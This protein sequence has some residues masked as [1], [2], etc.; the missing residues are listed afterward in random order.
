MAATILATRQEHGNHA[1]T[2]SDK[3]GN[4]SQLPGND[5]SWFLKAVGVTTTPTALSDVEGDGE[6]TTELVS[7][8]WTRGERASD[9]FDGWVPDELSHAVDSERRFRWSII[10]GVALTLA[11]I[12]VA[13]VWL[14]GSSDGRAATRADEY[15]RVLTDLRTDLPDAQSVLAQITEPGADA[16][17]FADL[18]PTVTDLRADAEMALEVAAEP[19]PSA[20]PLASAKPFEVLEPVRQTTSQQATT[21]QAIAR[22]LGEVLDY[23]SL[24]ARFLGT[25]DLPTRPEVDLSELNLRL[26]TAAADSAAILSELPADAALAAHTQLAR[27]GLERFTTWQVDYVDALRSDSTDEVTALLD[28]LSQI[29]AR[30]DRDLIA[31]IAQIRSEV[32]EAIIELAA[33]LDAA[34]ATVP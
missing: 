29:R 7:E 25:G 5:G 28:E 24:F 19:L 23:R 9:P 20:W 1:M 33:S 32:D 34:I 17:Q 16:T 31:G 12:A 27:N 3:P 14:A 4:G 2:S 26:A 11:L 6:S 13:G 18:I 30:L 21:A 10:I 15:R 22:R 8:L